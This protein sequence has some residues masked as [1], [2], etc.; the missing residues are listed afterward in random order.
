MNTVD[1][2]IDSLAHRIGV[3]YYGN[4]PLM[5]ARTAVELD[6]LLYLYHELWADI[7]ERKSDLQQCIG[8]SLGI[9]ILYAREHPEASEEQVAQEVVRVWLGISEKLNVPIQYEALERKLVETE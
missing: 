1:E 6:S 8:N 9:A 2:I 7:V 3:I 4:R 5:Y